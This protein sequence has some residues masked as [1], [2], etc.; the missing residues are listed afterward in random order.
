MEEKGIDRTSHDSSPLLVAKN[1]RTPYHRNIGIFAVSSAQSMRGMDFTTETFISLKASIVKT[2]K[3]AES[4]TDS[5]CQAK[6]EVLKMKAIKIED[7]EIMAC[8]ECDEPTDGERCYRC[9]PMTRDEVAET[10][11][12]EKYHFRK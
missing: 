4:I 3:S 10:I 8:P 1:T 12:C 9:E 7:S 5:G 11:G 6:S 2:P